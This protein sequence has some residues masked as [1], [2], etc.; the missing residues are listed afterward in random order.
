MNKVLDTGVNNVRNV[1]RYIFGQNCLAK[2]AEILTTHCT[3]PTGH[4]VYFV[5]SYFRENGSLIDRLPIEESDQVVFVSTVDEPT[6]DLI[7]TMCAQI[8]SE[9]STMPRA[10]VGVGGGIT[11]DT[12]KAI[13]NFALHFSLINSLVGIIVF[14]FSFAFVS[15]LL[16]SWRFSSNLRSLFGV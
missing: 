9:R 3:G 15:I 2:L 11:L 7:D 12:A 1:S 10:I 5:D 4:T 14:P 6:T 16:S 13:S 8:L